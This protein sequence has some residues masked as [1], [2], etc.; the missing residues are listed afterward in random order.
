MKN[1]F[2]VFF[3]ITLVVIFLFVSLFRGSYASDV[4]VNTV[5]LDLYNNENIEVLREEIKHF[6]DL[7]DDSIIVNSSYNLSGELNKNY[8]FLTRF[9][10]SFILDNEES[11]DILYGDNKIYQDEYGIK[12]VSN[13]YVSLTDIYEVTNKVLG[14]DYYYI[15]DEEIVVDDMVLLVEFMNNDFD[16]IIEEIID[17]KLIDGYYDVYV[18]YINNDIKY[19]FR[20]DIM[21]DNRLVISNLSVGD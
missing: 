20:F 21:D 16:M 6:I 10:I 4:L 2:V 3:L 15:L 9:A 7:V 8:D 19:I 18:K 1:K 12:Y 13:K 5:N 11:Y 14:V 17:I